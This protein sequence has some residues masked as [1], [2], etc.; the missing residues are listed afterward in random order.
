VNPATVAYIELDA[1]ALGVMRRPKLAVLP[2][3]K[4][5]GA[6]H[7]VSLL[8]DADTQQ[9]GNAATKAGLQWVWI[10]LFNGEPPAAEKDIELRRRLEELVNIIRG[11][12]RVILHCSAGLHRTGMCAYAVLRLSGFG[13]DRAR[14][15]LSTVR[16]L[17]EV[18]EHRL[19]WGDRLA[20]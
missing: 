5:Q 8:A 1:G 16:D 11:G 12:G 17:A 18:G 4:Q 15:M 20:S 10:P 9:L 13:R 19:S 14:E 2:R 3:L 7:L 6:T